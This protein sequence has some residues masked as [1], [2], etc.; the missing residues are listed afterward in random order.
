MGLGPSASRPSGHNTKRSATAG[1]FF[2]CCIAD[3]LGDVAKM[4]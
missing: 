3:H 2:I 4:V 1:R